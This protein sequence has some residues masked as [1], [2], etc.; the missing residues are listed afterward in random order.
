[1]TRFLHRHVDGDHRDLAPTFFLNAEGFLRGAE[2][3]ASAYPQAAGHSLA[4]SLELALKGHLLERGISD[5]WN[6]TY[7]RHDLVKALR[8]VRRIGVGGV[9]SELAPVAALLTPFYARHEFCRF[10]TSLLL[11]EDWRHITTA[12]R[13]AI[14]AR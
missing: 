8:A 10:P 3:T 7:L 13:A 1:M 5:D 9:P 11:D 12:V 14:Q 6:R 2:S 4:I